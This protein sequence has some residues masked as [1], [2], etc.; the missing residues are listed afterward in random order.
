[1]GAPP[2]D[3]DD[4]DD[5][6][7]GELNGLCKVSLCRLNNGPMDE[8]GRKIAEYSGDPFDSRY[9][10]QRVSVLVQRYNSILFRP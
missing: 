3:D 5:D 7:F 9:F 4:D 8:S 10:S 1:M 2:D 6:G